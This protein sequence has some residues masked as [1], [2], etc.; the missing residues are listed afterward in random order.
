MWIQSRTL[1]FVFCSEDRFKTLHTSLR[2][3]EAKHD[4][5]FTP[6]LFFR[7]CQLSLQ[8]HITQNKKIQHKLENCFY[9]CF[10]NIFTVNNKADHYLL[11]QFKLSNLLNTALAPTTFLVKPRFNDR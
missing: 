4:I 1:D 2:K 11:L 9:L 7:E 5:T 8:Y 10:T 3:Y 6:T